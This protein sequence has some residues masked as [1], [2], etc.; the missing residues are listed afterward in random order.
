MV[1]NLSTS[2]LTSLRCV[3]W[4]GIC[5]L[6]N[7]MGPLRWKWGHPIFPFVVKLIYDIYIWYIYIYILLWI[8]GIW[9]CIHMFSTFN[10][11][12]SP[13]WMWVDHPFPSAKRPGAQH[14]VLHVSSDTGE[15]GSRA[16]VADVRGSRGKR[17]RW[18][19]WFTRPVNLL[20]KAIENGNRN[21][22]FSH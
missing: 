14:L 10:P 17:G 21:S 6:W 8:Y 12:L 16:E 5:C 1:F 3:L 13:F 4:N 20:E 15:D 2:L 18:W 22:E 19:I 9:L 7:A 11:M